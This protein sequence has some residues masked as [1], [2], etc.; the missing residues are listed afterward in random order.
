MN[1]KTADVIAHINQHTPFLRGIRSWAG[2]AQI[3]LPYERRARQSGTTKYSLGKLF[4]LAASGLTSFSKTPLRISTI[5]GAVISTLSL[6]YAILV[7]LLKLFLGYP[8]GS[9][10][11]TSLAVLVSLL[12]GVQL[13]VLGILG[14]YLGHIFDAVR[15]IPPFH[16]AER[17]GFDAKITEAKEEFVIHG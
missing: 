16:L 10:G 14:E 6:V 12:S 17:S 13:M 1:R 8:A 7:V 11:W 9:G 5:V 3:N 15:G 4:L 2:G